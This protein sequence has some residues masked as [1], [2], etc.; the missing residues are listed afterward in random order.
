MES[1]ADLD[2]MHENTRN[3]VHALTTARSRTQ[4]AD[5]LLV[6]DACADGQVAIQIDDR[7]LALGGAALGA[8]LNQLAAQALTKARAEV[9]GAVET[10]C[11]DPRIADAIDATEDAMS[12]PLA[13]A[14]PS[15]AMKHGVHGA[16][17]NPHYPQPPSYEQ[18]TAPP[19]GFQPQ[20]S[21]QA[22]TYDDPYMDDDYDP[23]YHR[24]SWLE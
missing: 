19:S 21:T 24:K 16:P 2:P 9:R 1:P 17:Q 11:S 23:Y 3:L 5:G 8:E 6:V 12:Q 18:P 20:R 13:A 22:P 7:A 15:P 4:S 10:F 14:P